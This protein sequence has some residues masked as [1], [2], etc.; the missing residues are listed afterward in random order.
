[1]Q[2]GT[3]RITRETFTKEVANNSL[4][5]IHFRALGVAPD[6]AGHL[7]KRSIV[8]WLTSQPKIVTNWLTWQDSASRD[9]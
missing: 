9:L 8:L 6:Q 4:M 1:M 5:D 2:E 7:R 3:G